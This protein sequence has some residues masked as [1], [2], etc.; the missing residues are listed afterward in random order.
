MQ[1]K[2]TQYAGKKAVQA[3]CNGYDSNFLTFA[4][5]VRGAAASMTV[6]GRLALCRLAPVSYTHLN[7]LFSNL[8]ES[9]V[10]FVSR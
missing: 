8:W 1:G 4:V 9:F 2:T 3:V 7:T 6:I 10:N 5:V